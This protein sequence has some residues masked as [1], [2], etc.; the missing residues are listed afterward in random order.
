MV[1]LCFQIVVRDGKLD[2]LVDDIE[3]VAIHEL[4]EIA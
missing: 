2:E 3:E 4:L 1:K